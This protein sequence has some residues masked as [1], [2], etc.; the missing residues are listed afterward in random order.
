LES[1][2]DDA[3]ANGAWKTIRENVKISVK[4]KKHNL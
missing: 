1:I 2:D 4:G 3:D